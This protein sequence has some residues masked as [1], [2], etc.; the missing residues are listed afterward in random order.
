MRRS[1]YSLRGAFIDTRSI[2]EQ[3]CAARAGEDRG[4]TTSSCV[5]D[6]R[7]GVG[8]ADEHR[9]GLS[10][11]RFSG[12]FI[13][14]IT[15]SPSRSTVQCSVEMGRIS[16]CVR[17]CG[18]RALHGERSAVRAD[19]VGE[20]PERRSPL[21]DVRPGRGQRDDV[22]EVRGRGRSRASGGGRTGRRARDGRPAARAP[23]TSAAGV[24]PTWIARVRRDAERV[25]REVEDR[26]VGLRR[27]RRPPSRATAPTSTPGPGPDLADA[28]GPQLRLDGAVGVGH[29]RDAR[30]P[31]AA[32]AAQRVAGPR[33]SRGSRRRRART[34]R[35]GRSIA[36]SRSLVGHADDLARTR[37]CRRAR[38]GAVA[39]VP[40]GGRRGGV[41]R[42]HADVVR[43]VEVV[44]VGGRPRDAPARRSMRSWS[45]R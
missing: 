30:R 37:G 35:A 4:S 23:A 19:S 12:R 3:N 27:R 24:S 45:G 14:M 22:G 18:L 7:V 42:G 20:R 13:V 6:V 16:A 25:E 17:P 28:V 21:A 8:E 31:V 29:D 32:M 10:A 15:T 9:R 2:P 26:R 44:G 40:S 39:V 33:G 41:E 1:T 43:P 36:W 38:G 34:P 5:V 11:L